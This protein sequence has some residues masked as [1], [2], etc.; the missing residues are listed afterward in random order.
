MTVIRVFDN[1]YTGTTRLSGTRTD[2][3]HAYIIC[4]IA[5]VLILY[6]ATQWQIFI[7][8]LEYLWFKHGLLPVVLESIASI[9][10]DL[11]SGVC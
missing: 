6:V 2:D 4:F 8:E 11:L 1:D 5:I 7:C 10:Y 3:E 9:N